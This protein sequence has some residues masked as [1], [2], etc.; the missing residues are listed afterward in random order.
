MILNK[1]REKL[2]VYLPGYINGNL[3]PIL[4][5]GISRW[6][7]L[8]PEGQRQLATARLLKENANSLTYHQPSSKVLQRLRKQIKYQSGSQSKQSSMWPV[9]AIQIILALLAFILVW[10]G[11]PPGII[12][13]WSVREG[14]P[15][16]FLIYRAELESPDALEDNHFVL[17]KEIPAHGREKLYEFMDMRL[18]PG[19]TYIYRVEAVD[20]QGRAADAQS[21]TGQ[22]LDV[23]PSQLALIFATSVVAYVVLQ[24]SRYRYR[25]SQL[26]P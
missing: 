21:I 10:R 7:R 8:D 5:F 12:L 14:E 2:A 20:Q 23:L 24:S 19:Q 16:K 11:L 6:T 25:I 18:L 3:H 26:V 22:G 15:S 4:Q 17:L 9:W 1:V 13:K